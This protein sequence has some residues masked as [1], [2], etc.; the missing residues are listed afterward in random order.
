MK[1]I[2]EEMYYG[3]RGKYDTVKY[4][5]EYWNFVSQHTVLCEAFVAGL[6]DLQK[7]Q[8]KAIDEKNGEIEEEVITA[9]FKE[10]FKIGFLIAVECFTK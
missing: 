9:Q 7:A 10:G 5:E 2:I 1:S 8:F 3:K 6:T 4:S